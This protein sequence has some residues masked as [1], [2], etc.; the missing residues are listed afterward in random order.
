[1]NAGRA[2][3]PWLARVEVPAWVA[4][5]PQMLNQLHAALIGQCR[6]MGSRPYPYLL[7]RAHE[8]AMVSFQ[9]QDQVTQMILHELRRRGVEVGQESQ[10]QALKK[11]PGK[12]RIKG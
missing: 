11:L 6:I 3:R 9:E 7:H 1:L 5:N 10:K 8:A 4:I 12:T 2:G